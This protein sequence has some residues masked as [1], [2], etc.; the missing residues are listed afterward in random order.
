MKKLVKYYAMIVKLNVLREIE[1]IS[2]MV[3]WGLMSFVQIFANVF[4]IKIL[5]SRFSHIEGYGAEQII[6]IYG[7]SQISQ[8][9]MQFTM[10]QTWNIEEYVING[11]FDRMFLR[12]MSVLFQFLID[13]VNFI[14]LFNIAGGLIAFLYGAGNIDFLVNLPNCLQLILIII[15]GVL[16]QGGE[17]LLLGCA[18]FF[19]KRTGG[20]TRVLTNLCEK[21]SY[22]PISVFPKWMQFLV[23]Y[24]LPYTFVAFVHG[25]KAVHNNGS[26]DW[27]A[28]LQG[29]I[30]SVIVFGSALIVFKISIKH[31]E[32]AG[33]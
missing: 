2:G 6:F 1:H 7:I 19:F 23:T 32:S 22:Y 25:S 30:I 26:F 12:P 14:G 10:I 24:I 31:Y 29:L 21:T 5:M 27:L 33:H 20:S 11:A 8:G 3:S 4:L 15:E 18:A 28:T 9:C 17:F 13:R 16:I